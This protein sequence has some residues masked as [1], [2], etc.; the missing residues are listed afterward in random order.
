VI[1]SRDFAL[2]RMRARLIAILMADPAIELH[3][4]ELV[5]RTGG[6]PRAVHVA[7][8]QLERQRVISS[9]RV[10]GLRL[11]SASS[12]SPLFRPLQELAKRTLGVPLLLRKALAG[13]KGVDLAFIYGSY[14][15]GTEDASSDIDVFV[16]GD[17]EWRGIAQL[18]RDA[19][20]T[21]GRDVN[22]IAWTPEQLTRARSDPFLRSV[23]RQPKIW[24]V[25]K[26]G[27]LERRTRSMARSARRVGSA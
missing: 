1:D 3:T 26:E 25:G 24:L 18:T 8:E 9:R 5:R 22:V 7:L 16:L 10:G 23:R 11:W 14:A 17:P 15:L 6:S 20:E 2:G 4:R 27:D 12:D 13:Q 19:K 21:F